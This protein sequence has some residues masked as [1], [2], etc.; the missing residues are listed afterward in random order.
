MANF[1]GPQQAY[2]LLRRYEIAPP[3]KAGNS[4]VFSG[5][6]EVSLGGHKRADGRK[7]LTLT[8]G[9]VSES[10]LCPFGAGESRA[11]VRRFCGQHGLRGRPAMERALERLIAKAARMYAGEPIEAFALEKIRLHGGRYDIGSVCMVGGQAAAASPAPAADDAVINRP[12][13]VSRRDL[14]SRGTY[15]GR[16]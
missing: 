16:S 10:R 1:I 5:G 13:T 12:A 3:S 2:E 6:C 9:K 7:M 11:I 8:I 4:R 15:G 14:P